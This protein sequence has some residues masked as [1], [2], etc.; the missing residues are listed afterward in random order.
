M[1]F[2]EHPTETSVTPPE[3]RD[4]QE[5]AVSVRNDEEVT[6]EWLHDR[7][8]GQS[9]PYKGEDFVPFSVSGARSRQS[10]PWRPRAKFHL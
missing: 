6:R 2:S 9:L 3:D 5:T 1:P 8:R 7:T 10:V 4:S